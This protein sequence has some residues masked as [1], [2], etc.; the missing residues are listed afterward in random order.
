[1]RRYTDRLARALF[2][3]QSRLRDAG[4]TRVD[5]SAMTSRA[6]VGM[7]QFLVVGAS[8]AIAGGKQV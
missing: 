3:S 4:K 8:R 1:M 5:C 7:C 2:A 6:Q